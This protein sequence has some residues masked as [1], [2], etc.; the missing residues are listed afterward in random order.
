MLY[1]G[2]AN[3]LARR[4][5]KHMNSQGARFTRKYKVTQPVWFGETDDA[6]E[7]VQMEKRF[8]AWTR[9][10]K[11]ALIE[12]LNPAWD[13]LASARFGPVQGA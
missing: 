1:T 9:A 3:G 10:E 5:W 8:R 11:I 2:S 13:V 7:K 6:R 4:V 12:S